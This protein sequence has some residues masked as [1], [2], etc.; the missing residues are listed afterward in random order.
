MVKSV[1]ETSPIPIDMLEID[2]VDLDMEDNRRAHHTLD[3]EYP[4]LVV[5]RGQTFNIN[6]T[7][8]KPLPRGMLV[9]LCRM[10]KEPKLK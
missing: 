1:V 4:G 3:Y 8:T 6:L 9:R 5:R 10:L 2:S 7:T